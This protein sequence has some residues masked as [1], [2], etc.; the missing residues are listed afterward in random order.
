[1]KSILTIGAMFFVFSFCGLTEKLKQI[2]GGANSSNS[3]SNSTKTRAQ[4][5]T[6]K[7]S[8]TSAQQAILDGATEVKWDQQGISWKLPAGWKKMDVKKET[9]NYDTPDNA[10]LL[11][12][13]SLMNDD[14]RWTA[15]GRHTTT[16][17]STN[18]TG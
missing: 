4:A 16:S 1:M 14:F 10:A 5:A 15:A 2:Q 17:S 3:S 13:I 6:E 11:V 7:A 18:E 9:F 8:M 12:N